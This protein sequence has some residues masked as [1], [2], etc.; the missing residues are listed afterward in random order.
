MISV[1]L[2]QNW[3]NQ[4]KFKANALTQNDLP[5]NTEKGRKGF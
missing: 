2:N 1:S 5:P 3:Y 4:C